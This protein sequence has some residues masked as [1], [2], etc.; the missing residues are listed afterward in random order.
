MSA[1][2]DIY[3][4]VQSAIHE[5]KTVEQFL[6]MAWESWDDVMYEETRYANLAFDKAVRHST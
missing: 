6:K 1:E 5:G 2:Q 3:V 4:A